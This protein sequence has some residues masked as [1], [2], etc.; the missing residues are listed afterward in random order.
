MVA[1]KSARLQFAR[2][3]LRRRGQ[4]LV[5]R[6]APVLDCY[7]LDPPP[8]IDGA[9]NDWNFVTAEID[10]V[11]FRLGYDDQHLYLCYEVRNQGP[12]RNT[13]TQWDRLFKTGASVDLQL[14]LDPAAPED[15][16]APVA[17]DQRLLLTLMG[18]QPAA[19]LYQA[20]I[21]GTPED[22]A[23]RA[24]SPVAE[25]SFDRV[26]RLDGVRLAH[27][28]TSDDRGYLVE[29]AIPLKS[30][31]LKIQPNLR[32]KLDWGIL[33]SGRDGNEVLRRLYWSNKA[34][35][36]I[37]DAPSEA[38]LHPNLWGHIRFHPDNA[39]TQLDPTAKKGRDK[40]FDDLLNELK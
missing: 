23:W 29:A 30:F 40:G 39:A 38:R 17:G 20:V 37:A 9:I 35:G 18:E 8:K 28:R 13:G 4:Q 24:V 32:L 16:R 3:T 31:G 22:Q 19:V 2:R 21:P 26:T 11:K 1:G 33:A 12:F 15:R 6:R 36:V 27:A 34:T 5:Y 25:V 7:R 14:A 10:D